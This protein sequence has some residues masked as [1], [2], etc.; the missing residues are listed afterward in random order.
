MDKFRFSLLQYKILIL[1]DN[2]AHKILS[3]TDLARQ[4]HVLRPSVSRAIHTLKKRGMILYNNETWEITE[5]G[6]TKIKQ[7]FTEWESKQK[8]LQEKLSLNLYQRGKP[9]G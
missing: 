3:L 8:S 6:K 1:L 5:L 9:N 7:K 4:L 2:P